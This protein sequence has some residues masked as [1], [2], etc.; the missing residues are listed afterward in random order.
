MGIGKTAVKISLGAGETFFVF[1][2]M[3][4]LDGV[5]TLNMHGNGVIV[6]AV[7]IKSDGL[8]IFFELS[9]DVG[10]EF[11]EAWSSTGGT[12]EDILVL[13]LI[14]LGVL[15]GINESV[16]ELLEML[17]FRN[18]DLSFCALVASVLTSQV[19]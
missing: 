5:L 10:K 7:A 17:N 18:M 8:A 14:L 12:L 1:H 15:D 9:N 3:G 16:I 4:E 2:D 19:I 11:V 6:P 13:G